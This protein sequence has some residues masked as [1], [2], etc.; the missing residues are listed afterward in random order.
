MLIHTHIN[1]I[2]FLTLS[3]KIMPQKQEKTRP[4]NMW[5]SLCFND[6]TEIM[7]TH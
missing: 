1:V 2:H 6:R 7:Q 5:T 4:Q 3:Q